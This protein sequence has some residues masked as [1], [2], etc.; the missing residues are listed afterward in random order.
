MN[1]A[2]QEKIPVRYATDRA[3][4]ASSTAAGLAQIEI[5]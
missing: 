3:F 2:K 1:K 4:P 5:V